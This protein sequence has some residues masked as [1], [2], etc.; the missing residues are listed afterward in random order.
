MQFTIG[1]SVQFCLGQAFELNLGPP[2]ISLD[3]SVLEN[4]VTTCL[5]GALGV[6]TILWIIA[7]EANGQHGEYD[8]N[9]PTAKSAATKG[10]K[11]RARIV[12]IFQFLVNV[13]LIAVM[14]AFI[15]ERRFDKELDKKLYDLFRVEKDER[16]SARLQ[17]TVLKEKADPVDTSDYVIFDLPLFA[18]ALLAILIPLEAAA[19]EAGI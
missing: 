2:K 10:D 11:E 7:Y 18:V 8:P 17:E 9:D 4:P 16:E 5:C 3:G 1:S 15:F 14:E 13:L 6:A 12:I 19:G